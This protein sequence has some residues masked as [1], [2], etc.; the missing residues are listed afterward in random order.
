MAIFRCFS[1]DSQFCRIS[2]FRR[3]D[4]TETRVI[5]SHAALHENGEVD[6]VRSIGEV[7]I[8]SFSLRDPEVE[9]TIDSQ[10]SHGSFVHSTREKEWNVRLDAVDSF[11]ATN[12]EQVRGR[13]ELMRMQIQ[14]MELTIRVKVEEAVEPHNDFM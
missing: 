1:G 8:A 10:L 7:D 12:G 3:C 2:I 5:V 13:R 6:E 4:A 9:L 14:K 11:I